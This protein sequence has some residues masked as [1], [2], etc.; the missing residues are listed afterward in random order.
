MSIATSGTYRNYR[1]F[2]VWAKPESW[3]PE[4]AMFT[5]AERSSAVKEGLKIIARVHD[6]GV[7]LIANKQSLSHKN[8]SKP[9]EQLLRL[10]TQESGIGLVPP[11]RLTRSE[12]DTSKFME[13]G[14]N[15]TLPSQRCFLN[16]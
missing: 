3:P 4:D 14:N 1:I 6:G 16:R 2:D 13:V 12:V 8:L 11:K 10:P 9:L 5:I 15:P 7:W